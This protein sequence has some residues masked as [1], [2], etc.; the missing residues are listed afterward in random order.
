MNFDTEIQ[1]SR[2]VNHGNQCTWQSQ[3]AAP[4][5]TMS[6]VFDISSRLTLISSDVEMNPGPVQLEDVLEAVNLSEN[7]ILSEIKVMQTEMA[8]LK[9]DIVVLK[10]VNIAMKNSVEKLTSI[11]NTLDNESSKLETN[12]K[13]L[14]E[15]TENI[16]LD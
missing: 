12:V 16:T 13:I 6:T 5:I 14:Q 8:D 3:Y 9:S 2:M 4:S 15:V 10:E 1:L 7:C 11:T